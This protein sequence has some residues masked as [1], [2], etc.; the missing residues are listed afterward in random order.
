MLY[1]CECLKCGHQMESEKH[2]REIKCPECGGEMRRQDRPGPGQASLSIEFVTAAKNARV[3]GVAYAGGKMNLPGW[4]HPIVVDLAGLTIPSEVPLLANHENRTAS[5]VGIVHPKV[6]DGALLIEGDILSSSGTAQGIIEQAKAGGDWQLSIGADIEEV[7]LVKG[8][9]NVNGQ[10]HSGPFYHISKSTLREVSVVAVGAD[11]FTRMRV[12]AHWKFTEGGSAMTFEAWLK[13]NG[14]D[15]EGLSD[16]QTAKFRVAFE[17]G[18]EPPVLDDDPE[19]AGDDDPEDAGDDEPTYDPALLKREATKAVKAERDRIA[20][21]QDACGGEF[22]EIEREAIR[23]GWT[24]ERTTRG[25]LRALRENR[26]KTGPSITVLS[27]TNR[28]KESRTLEAAMCL[29]A[30]LNEDALVKTYG[31]DVVEAALKDREIAL[32]ELMVEC[33]RMEG[34]ATPRTFGND[35][36]RAAFSTVSL[37]GILNNV[38]NKR[39]L[40]AYTAQPVLA[41]RLCSVGDLNDFKESERYRLTDV[42]DLEQVAQDGELKHGGVSE[43]KATNQLATYGKM[44]S[45]T[46]QMIYN[47]DLGAFLRVPAGM[48]AR[49]ARKVDQLFFTRM[50]SNPKMEDG[51]DL[52]HADHNN[53]ESGSGTA[54]DADS[55]AT[56]LQLFLDQTD[57]DGEP[58]NIAPAFLLVPTALK[59]DGSELLNSSFL[60][61]VGNTDAQRLPTYN[62]IADEGLTLVTSPYLSNSNYTGNSALAWYLWGNPAVVD[63]FEIGYLRGKR[64]PT[65]ERGDTDFNTLGIQFRVYFDLGVREQDFRGIVKMKGEA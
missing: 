13:K 17:A 45:L 3:A 1:R 39:L 29:R 12:A 27:T 35:T 51:I 15:A 26:P 36:I 18:D 21:I 40:Q 50:L 20:A 28:R 42:G 11:K 16:E 34:K 65:I 61:S 59:M 62:A 58:I 24:M 48:G 22:D 64:T 9:Q 43:E 7:E 2:C 44:F 10:L 56:A 52:F 4:K 31:E 57:S 19:D 54:L 6:Q 14:I 49:A 47:D 46:R 5:R 30:G 32:R 41:T 38:A 60:L 63:T 23:A 8:R 25:V 55:M 33:A 53:Y 37:P